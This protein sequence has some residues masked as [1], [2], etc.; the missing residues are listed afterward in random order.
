MRLSVR[1]LVPIVLGAVLASC[2]HVDPICGCSPRPVFTLAP[3]S[4]S[5][6]A[7]D[8]AALTVSV[9]D[10]PERTTIRLATIDSAVA[11]VDS[12]ARSGV[13]VRVRAGNAGATLLLVTTTADGHTA[14]GTVPVTVTARPAAARSAP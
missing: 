2:E 11:R 12:V 10:A 9:H 6:V 14:T 3:S 8:S 13:P 5:L 1:R 7:G 4:L